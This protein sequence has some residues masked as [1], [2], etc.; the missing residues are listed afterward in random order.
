MMGCICKGRGIRDGRLHVVSLWL[1]VFVNAGVATDPRQN[2]RPLY[3]QYEY[4]YNK[5]N[6]K[7]KRIKL[8]M[9]CNNSGER[10]VSLHNELASKMNVE[11]PLK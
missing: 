7:Y 1:R 10:L 4:N 2:I 11:F 6:K 5:N 3:T 9:N 8:S